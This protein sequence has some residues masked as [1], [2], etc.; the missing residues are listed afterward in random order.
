MSEGG[1]SRMNDGGD[2]REDANCSCEGRRSRRGLKGSDWRAQPPRIGGGKTEAR[3]AGLVRGRERMT[4]DASL[5]GPPPLPS[6]P[7]PPPPPPWCARRAK[8]PAEL[9]SSQSQ[10]K[11][12]HKKK[13][14]PTSS[15]KTKPKTNHRC[16]KSWELQ[17]IF[18]LKRNKQKK[19][20]GGWSVLNLPTHPRYIVIHNVHWAFFHLWPPAAADAAVW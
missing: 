17:F 19:K 11:K 2:C 9:S 7:P 13:T 8:K 3:S 4:S 6:P 10:K 14:P 15:S 20:V 12:T 16:V 18:Y 5:H 1:R